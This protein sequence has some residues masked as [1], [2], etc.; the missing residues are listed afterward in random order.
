MK[1]TIKYPSWGL[2]E[3]ELGGGIV[4]VVCMT[5]KGV[6]SIMRLMSEICNQNRL[7]LVPFLRYC[8]QWQIQ[9][10]PGEGV[11]TSQGG[12]QHMILPKVP[13]NCMK[14]KEFGPRGH[15]SKILLCRSATGLDK[16]Y[17]MIMWNI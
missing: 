11:P 16:L 15:A 10:F 7:K 17:G 13:K 4:L 12:S 2:E 8:L 5:Q 3:W 6:G 9:D 14:L 1:Q